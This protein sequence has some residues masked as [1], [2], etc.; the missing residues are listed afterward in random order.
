MYFETKTVN[1]LFLK[2]ENI[3]EIINFIKMIL[4][5]WCI[6]EYERGWNMEVQCLNIISN[7]FY[8]TKRVTDG[9]LVLL[10]IKGVLEIQQFTANIKVETELLIVNH[11]EIFSIKRNEATI[12]LYKAS[13][14][15]LERGYPFFDYQYASKLIQSTAQL[16]KS[17]IELTKHYLN[18][19]LSY[20]IY[21]NYMVKIV[22]IIANE[23]KVDSD[24]LSQQTD[25]AYFGITGEILDYVNR[26]LKQPL[27]LKSIADHIFISQSNIS[28]QFYS[29]LDMNFKT[30]VDTLKLAASMKELLDSQHTIGEISDLYGFSSAAIYSKKFKQYYGYTPNQYRKLSKYNKYLYFPYETLNVTFKDQ[31][32]AQLTAKLEDSYVQNNE[33]SICTDHFL[34]NRNSSMIIQIYTIAELYQLYTDPKMSYLFENEKQ[35]YIYCNINV[36]DIQQY[37]SEQKTYK[38]FDFI[39]SNNANLVL[40]IYESQDVEIYLNQ[41]CKPYAA[42]LQTSTKLNKD[43]LKKISYCF[44]LSTMS[45]KEIYRNIIKIKQFRENVKFGI[46]ITRLFNEPDAF[47]MME[48]QL[49]R[50]GFEYYFVDNQKLSVPC[51]NESHEMLLTKEIFKFNYIRKIMAEMCLED[52]YYFL[53]NVRNNFLLHD[54]SMNIIESPP[55]LVGVFKR[56]LK[57]FSGIGVDLIQQMNGNEALY[58]YDKSG[59][60]T[61]IGTMFHRLIEK[62]RYKVYEHDFYTIIDQEDKISVYISDWQI[63]E[64]EV[65]KHYTTKMSVN[66]NFKDLKS[67]KKYLIFKETY[68]NAHGNIN[69]VIPC[70]LREKYPWSDI[71]IE[72][73]ESYN[74]PRINVFEHSFNDKSLSV[75]IDHN[76]VHII[77]IYK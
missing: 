64:N 46:D 30:Y 33:I 65:S 6:T 70:N 50:I 17:L 56:I 11:T 31:V 20:D 58:L 16:T 51:F 75:A 28:S 10:P 8:P 54:E 77:D 12:L 27:T 35:I 5:V 19:T 41:I 59:F 29:K 22:E 38:A 76:T 42:Y 34:D 37:I 74:Q 1:V 21:E 2:D 23:A 26:N 25:H 32:K 72:K 61:L 71:F 9:I 73:I 55:L 18:D 14:W 48:V 57:H 60:R 62:T 15:F 68:N 39:I 47:K 45:I 7:N 49:K 24:Y 52:R 36:K 53:L 69:C 63:M 44:D 67:R 43:L 3:K 13:D 4:Y 66:I 40:Q